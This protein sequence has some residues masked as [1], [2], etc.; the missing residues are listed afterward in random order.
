VGENGVVNLKGAA[1]KKGD[2]DFSDF[3]FKE[4]TTAVLKIQDIYL[5]E[6]GKEAL[7]KKTEV[8]EAPVAPKVAGGAKGKKKAGAKSA[9]KATKA[10]KSEDKP[11]ASGEV[12]AKVGKILKYTPSKSAGKKEGTPQKAGGKISSKKPVSTSKK[13]PAMPSPGG[14]KSTK[15]TD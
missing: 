2:E 6:K 4:G 15:T 14:K 8:H 9:A 13:T 1:A 11:E 3:S 12:G 7:K 10:A 5:Q